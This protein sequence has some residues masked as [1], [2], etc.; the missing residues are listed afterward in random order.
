MFTA[1]IIHDYDANLPNRQAGEGP[2]T[3]L[4]TLKNSQSLEHLVLILLVW[5]R[6][7]LGFCGLGFTWAEFIWFTVAESLSGVLIFLF[8]GVFVPLG[9]D[10]F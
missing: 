1:Q 8:N 2:A 4:A 3:V 9:R 10:V 5:E 6:V 7:L